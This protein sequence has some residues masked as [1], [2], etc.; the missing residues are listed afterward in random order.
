[1]NDLAMWSL[2]VGALLPPVVAL[3][4]RPTWLPWVRSVVTVGACII[5]GGATAWF[6]GS[7]TGPFTITSILLILTSALATYKGFWKPTE[8]APKIEAATSPT[9]SA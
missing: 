3:V 1:V 9:T 6:S 2:I 4:Q 7:L 8:I 5:A